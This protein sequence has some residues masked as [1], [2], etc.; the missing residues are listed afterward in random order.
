MLDCGFHG[1]RFERPGRI[2]DSD[3]REE[4]ALV[5]LEGKPFGMN[6]DEFVVAS[7][8]HGRVL[9][10]FLVD[11]HDGSVELV[12]VARLFALGGVSEVLTQEEVGEDF[13]LDLSR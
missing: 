5:D 9:V 4:S 11:T 2:P 8:I 10:E 12:C 1:G 6:E 13:I 3:V 7:E